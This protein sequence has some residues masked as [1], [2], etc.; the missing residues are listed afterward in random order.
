MLQFRGGFFETAISEE[1]LLVTVSVFCVSCKLEIPNLA[2]L[3]VT[4]ICLQSTTSNPVIPWGH[5]L[6]LLYY[7]VQ[8]W[9]SQYYVAMLQEIFS[10]S[11]PTY[12]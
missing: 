5:L 11:S 8:V 9:A 7:T 4:F 10:I 12:E 3:Y 2:D 1:H 6:D